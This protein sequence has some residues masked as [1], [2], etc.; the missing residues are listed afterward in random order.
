MAK[1]DIIKIFGVDDILNIPSSIMDLIGGDVCR[2]N[3]VYLELLQIH[4][5]DVSFD[6]FQDVYEKE[7]AQRSQDKQDFTPAS[8]SQLC[9]LLTGMPKGILHEPTAGGGSMIIADWWNRCQSVYPWQY[10]PSEH[11]YSCWELSPRAI[12]FLLLNLS[13]RGISGEVIHGDVLERKINARYVLI[14]EYDNPLD[15]SLIVR[16]DQTHT[17]P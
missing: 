12:P 10:R 6:W 2:R 5:G 14:N 15:F 16:D 8:I 13:I 7:F 1:Q 9:S 17:L 4:K 3:E 11:L